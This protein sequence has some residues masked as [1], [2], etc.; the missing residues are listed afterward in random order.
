MPEVSTRGER[1]HGDH[2][3]AQG[4]E[5]AVSGGGPD[6]ASWRRILARR[7]WRPQSWWPA[8]GGLPQRARN[9]LRTP[10]DTPRLPLNPRLSMAFAGQPRPQPSASRVYRHG[11]RTIT[12]VNENERDFEHASV[13]L[14]PVARRR[15]R[16]RPH[17]SGSRV[18]RAAPDAVR[19][20][21]QAAPHAHHR[22]AH[23][24]AGPEPRR[25]NRPRIRPERACDSAPASEPSF[26]HRAP[27]RPSFAHATIIQERRPCAFGALELPPPA[28]RPLAGG[29]ASAASRIESHVN[30]P[31]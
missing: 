6:A 2:H 12:S 30:E 21:S 15:R 13:A 25:A 19:R 7:I 20:H 23:S 10:E 11:E 24:V 18:R 26:G 9:N 14:H 17:G 8:T 16:N 31:P 29:E 1:Q 27:R 5:P 22:H 3:D 28:T 4:T